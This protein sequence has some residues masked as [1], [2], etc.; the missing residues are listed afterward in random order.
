[1]TYPDT[2]LLINGEWQDAQDARTLAVANPA[3]GKEIGRVA[4]ASTADLDRALAAAQKGFETWR[5]MPAHERRKI[6]HRA[7]EL[8]RER[9]TDIRMPSPSPSVTIAVP[10]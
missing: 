4:H 8:M 2:Q 9:A 10:P 6:M 1:M 7:A 5:A 3:T